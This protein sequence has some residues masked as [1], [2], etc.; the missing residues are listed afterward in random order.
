MRTDVATFVC[1]RSMFVNGVARAGEA[2]SPRDGGQNARMSDPTER[3][4]SDDAKQ[5]REHERQAQ[6]HSDAERAPA[7][8]D[9]PGTADVSAPDPD[10]ADAR[11]RDADDVL[12]PPRHG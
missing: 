1:V 8:E 5:M 12:P 7:G 2:V 9:E 6:E 3:D 10:A 4:L 11:G